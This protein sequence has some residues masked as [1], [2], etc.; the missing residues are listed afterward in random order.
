MSAVSKNSNF[1]VEYYCF[2]RVSFPRFDF[3]QY[4]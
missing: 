2:I 3:I 1:V 4:G